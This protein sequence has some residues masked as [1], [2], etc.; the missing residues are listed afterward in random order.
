[1]KG[2]LYFTDDAREN[3]KNVMANEAATTISSVTG[4]DTALIAPFVI[5]GTSSLLA[6]R[7][8]AQLIAAEIV[9]VALEVSRLRTTTVPKRYQKHQ[10]PLIVIHVA[11]G[12]TAA[13]LSA[14]LSF[15]QRRRGATYLEERAGVHEEGLEKEEVHEAEQVIK[16]TRRGRE[17]NEKKMGMGTSRPLTQNTPNQPILFLH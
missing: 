17:T 6:P 10:Y 16:I 15:I 14:R 1:R 4:F 3:Q 2:C 12:L 7:E 5:T 9:V 8:H 11:S 13:R